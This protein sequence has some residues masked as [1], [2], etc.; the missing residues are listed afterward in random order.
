M[1]VGVLGS[2]FLKPGS[3]TSLT[4]YVLR[5]RSGSVSPGLLRP[6]LVKIYLAGIA[7]GNLGLAFVDAPAGAIAIAVPVARDVLGAI[8]E[9]TA[10][11]AGVERVGALVPAAEVLLGVAAV[12]FLA[13][14]DLDL[15]ARLG[16]QFHLVRARA[17][18]ANRGFD[19][20]MPGTEVATADHALGRRGS[21]A[22]C[23]RTLT[24]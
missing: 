5:I 7:E 17:Q 21:E 9:A 23:Y 6:V 14:L 18:A 16:A 8:G 20:A 11:A 10:L 3:P 13:P 4:H 15:L 22:D 12:G 19:V 1:V 24:T 2:Y